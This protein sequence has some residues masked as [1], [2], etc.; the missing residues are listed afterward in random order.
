MR[1]RTSFATLSAAA[2]TPPATIRV[3]YAHA[4]ARAREGRGRDIAL[5]SGASM[6]IDMH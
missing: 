5:A 3:C 1:M 4:R 2:K 6:Y